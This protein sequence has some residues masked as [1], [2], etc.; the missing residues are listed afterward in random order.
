AASWAG[1]TS[2]STKYWPSIRSKRRG[3]EMLRLSLRQKLSM[4]VEGSVISPDRTIGLTRSEIERLPI[5]VGN[6]SVHLGEYFVAAG[7]ANEPDIV[8]EGDCPSFRRLGAGMSRGLL[9]IEG[10][11]G[12]YLGARMSGGRIEVHGSSGAGLG[13]EMSGGVIDVRR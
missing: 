10:E 6:R 8:I 4:P 13:A 3:R 1:T 9:R 11:G 7:D 2:R 5:R 12:H